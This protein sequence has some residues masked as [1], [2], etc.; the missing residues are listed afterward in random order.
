MCTLVNY[1]FIK[2]ILISFNYQ[3]NEEKLSNKN[4]V[5]RKMI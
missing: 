3:R 2:R 4:V 5:L 1:T